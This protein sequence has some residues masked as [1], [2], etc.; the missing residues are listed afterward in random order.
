[1]HAYEQY[2]G[3]HREMP[4]VSIMTVIIRHHHTLKVAASS[5]W[6]AGRS[7]GF[8]GTEYEMVLLLHCSIPTPPTRSIPRLKMG[9]FDIHCINSMMRVLGIENSMWNQSTPPHHCHHHHQVV[10][11]SRLMKHV[12]RCFHSVLLDPLSS[13]CRDTSGNGTVNRHKR[14]CLLHPFHRHGPGSS[15]YVDLETLECASSTFS[16]VSL[17]IVE[18]GRPVRDFAHLYNNAV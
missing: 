12:G 16:P 10:K 15:S 6:A 1:M 18:N 7:L 13:I 11:T 14:S 3:K 9:S 8:S 5:S 2:S 4:C 17:A